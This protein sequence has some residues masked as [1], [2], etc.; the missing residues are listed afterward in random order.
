MG[1]LPS[2]SSIP[3]IFKTVL[4]FWF[5]PFLVVRVHFDPPYIIRVPLLDK[6]KRKNCP[7][8]DFD[9]SKEASWRTEVNV[10]N[11]S[12]LQNIISEKIKKNLE[13]LAFFAILAKNSFFWSFFLIFSER[14][15]WKERCIQ[16]IRTLLLSYQNPLSDK[17]SV[18]FP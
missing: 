7:I 13:K 1:M 2:C 5:Q 9:S 3:A 10:K 4:V 12:A 6:K 16:C 15:L 11:L 14:I 17:F 8:L 18:F